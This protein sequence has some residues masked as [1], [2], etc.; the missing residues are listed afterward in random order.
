MRNKDNHEN[1]L[2][3]VQKIKNI[4]QIPLL[5]KSVIVLFLRALGMLLAYSSIIFISRLFGAEVYGRFS[6]LLTTSQLLLLVFSLG[7]PFAMVKLTADEYFFKDYPINNYLLNALKIILVSGVIGSL[8]IYMISKT[9]AINVFNDYGLVTYFKTLSYF[10]VFIVLHS[11]FTEFLK[12]RQKFKAYGLFLFVMPYG[13]FLIIATLFYMQQIKTEKAIYLSYLI[14]FVVI[15]SILTFFI[16]IKKLKTKEK[17][18]YNK[19]FSLSM[20][21]LF[22][23]AFIFISNWTDVFMLGAMVTK[24]EVGIYNAAYKVA[25]ISLVIITSINTVLAPKLSRLHSQDKYSEI[26]KEVIKATK[27]ITYLT[28]PIITLILIFR[29]QILSVFGPEFIEGEPVLII[30]AIGLL[31]NAMSGSVGQI[32]NMTKYHKEL[33]NFT[34]LSAVINILLNYVLIIN[35]G[36]IGAAIASVISTFFLNFVCLAFIKKKLGFIAFFGFN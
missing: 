2:K 16:P 1:I 7:L 34:I 4:I 21:M 32:L 19:L 30:L 18:S 26:K 17:Y 25:T 13:L 5:K 23:A 14:P 9:L 36:I 28:I 31:F 8:F 6:L 10:F 12:G 29:K 20:P 11:F 22:S 27:L 35:Y 24:A 15:T 33:R 3:L